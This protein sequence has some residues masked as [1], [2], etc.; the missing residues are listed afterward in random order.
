MGHPTDGIERNEPETGVEGGDSTLLPVLPA[1]LLREAAHRFLHHLRVERSLSV[2]TVRA[3]AVDLAQVEFFVEERSGNRPARLQDL[4]KQEI[5][6]FLAGGRKVWQK[7]SQGRKLSTLRSFFRYL[8]DA[9]VVEGNPTEGVSHPRTRSKLP[10]F[11]GVD[12]VFHFLD[13]L[14]ELS[15]RPGSSWRRSRNWAL[16]E[17][18]YS[19]GLRVSELVGLNRVDLDLESGMLRVLGKGGKERVVPV[20]SKA[21]QAI[22]EYLERLGRQRL[23]V[24]DD[25]GALFRNA[26]GGRLTVR[27]VHRL[28]RSEMERCGLWQHISPHGLRHSFATHL[29][30]A[31]ADLRAI[32]EMLGHSSLSTTQRYTHVHLDQLMKVYDASHPRSRKSEHR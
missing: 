3:Y 2:E 20:G 14:R 24:S 27:S 6:A 32:Q 19:S 10:S 18:A 21:V 29:L 28:L 4:S 26:R 17:T 31:G 1:L 30:G 8:N 5:R 22:E 16:F 9:G 25:D 12:D 11:L 7:T 15:R 13:G 23:V